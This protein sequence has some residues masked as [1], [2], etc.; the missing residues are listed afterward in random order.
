MTYTPSID[1]V[2][3]CFILYKEGIGTHRDSYEEGMAFN[4][5]IAE[6]RKEARRDAFNAA[7][8]AQTAEL[9]RPG[10]SLRTRVS[11]EHFRNW[12]LR[13]ADGVK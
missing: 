12:L 5:M 8:S 7:A 1:E 11:T 2:R 13:L 10:L 4:R 6:V 3:R 9:Q